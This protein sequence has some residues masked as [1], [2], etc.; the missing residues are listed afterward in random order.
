M[1]VRRIFEGLL[2]SARWPA[3]ISP[4]N[5]VLA[6]AVLVAAV[7]LTACE[8]TGQQDYA[9]VLGEPETSYARIG[10]LYGN[11]LA[12]QEATRLKDSRAAANYYDRALKA[13]PDNQILLERAFMFE[14]SAGNKTKARDLASR[15]VENG[16]DNRLARLALAVREIERGR[17]STARKHLEESARGLYNGFAIDLIKAWIFA[18][19]R[20][21]QQAEAILGNLN[22]LGREDIYR[23]YHLALMYDAQGKNEL[24]EQHY[25]KAVEESDTVAIRIVDAYGRFL[26]RNKRP[27]EAVALYQAFLANLPDNALIEYSLRRATSAENVPDRLIKNTRDG[28][29]EAIY[30]V[31]G[32]LAGDRNIN[33]PIL[34]LQ[35]ALW[36]KPDFQE[37]RLLMGELYWQARQYE[38]SARAMASVPLDHPFAPEAGVQIALSLERMGR[39]EEAEKILLRA[40]ANHPN[41]PTATI[42]L[43]D[44]LRSNEKYEQAV[45]AYDRAFELLGDEKASWFLYYSRGASLEQAGFWT[46]AEIDLLAALERAPDQPI[47]LNHLGYSW[48]DRGLRLEEGLE[49]V[50]TAVDLSPGNGFIVDS[51]G[52][53]HFRLGEYDTAVK[54]LERALELEPEDP[55]LHEHLG[56]AYWM[57]NRKREAQF[58]WQHALERDPAQDQI[59]IIRA[60]LIDGLKHPEPVT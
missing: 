30:G 49:L 53:A 9:S 31:A 32:L 12:A 60:K 11:Y 8:T 5:G 50:R 14:V 51:L 6:N 17:M 1:R 27:L 20:D 40:I 3:V 18:S 28:V 58:Q 59:E 47:V 57:A 4:F 52:W 7:S 29:A 36:V 44:I 15:I 22:A 55:T 38:L 34:Y 42:A 39:P 23:S 16:S 48:V 19:E 35:M 2:R 25:R 24:A 41:D 10:T 13:D 43:G 33:L 54:Y 45:G 26:E 21:F 56:D 46:E 37:A